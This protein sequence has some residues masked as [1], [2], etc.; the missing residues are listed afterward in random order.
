MTWREREQRSPL[1]DP[2][3][4]PRLVLRFAFFT[5]LGLA[6]A[7]A[8]ILIVVR[9]ADTAQAGQQAIGRAQLTTQAALN[10]ELRAADLAEQID[11]KRRRQ[12]DRLFRTRVLLEGIQ[13]ARLYGADGHVAYATRGAGANM[14]REEDV[15]QALSGRLVS[16]VRSSKSGRILSTYVPLKLGSGGV[17]GVALLEQDYDR[18]AGA[19]RRTSWFIAGVLEALLLLLCVAF[20]PTLARVTSGIRRHI[21]DLDHIA[22]HDNLT[23]LLNRAGFRRAVER[24]LS[25][26]KRQSAIILLDVDG[27]SAINDL[28]G[29]ESADGLLSEVAH[30]LQRDLRDCDAVARLGEDEFGLFLRGADRLDVTIAAEA[31]HKALEPELVVGGMRLAVTASVGA[32]LFPEHGSDFTSLLRHAGTAL[33]IAKHEENRL[34]EIYEQDHEASE[35]ARIALAA[36]VRDALAG[37]ELLLHYQP[38]VDVSTRTVRG[39]EALLRWE[40]PER[41]LLT[42]GS[43]IAQAERS[44]LTGRLR[45]FAF[46][47]AARQWQ[48]WTSSGLELELAVN[49]AAMDL[50]DLSLAEEILVALEQH[51]VPAR[52]FLLEITERTLIADERRARRVLEELKEIGIRLSLDDFGV[53]YSSLASLRRF[54]MDQVKLDR[55]LIAGAPE[56]SA[57]RA[58]VRGSVEIAHALGAT[59]VAEGVETASEWDFVVCSGCDI[60]Q[61]YLI[62][63]AVPGDELAALVQAEPAVMPAAA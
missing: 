11:T 19:A 35:C 18:I 43:F 52:N 44:R 57:A 7:A 2:A 60:A 20:V 17:A 30:R 26:A 38:L 22:S 6:A 27:F 13:A 15:R 3:G 21:D 45:Q 31:V 10:G 40:H 24:E 48:D 51:D 53:G 16:D 5:A 50:L 47:T 28:V 14:G 56:D 49:V 37:G 55:S 62:G 58:I 42:A 63:K 33:S 54:P 61:G 59:V 29:A 46:K 25:R 9:R 8:A 36:E 34:V 23:E 12:L 39:A 4:A 41:G 32:A 1:A